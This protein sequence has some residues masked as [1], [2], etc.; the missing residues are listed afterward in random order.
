MPLLGDNSQL[1]V[2]V[3][4]MAEV[5]RRQSPEGSGYGGEVKPAPM[6]VTE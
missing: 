1:P 5:R 2:S 4:E 6:R 3:A